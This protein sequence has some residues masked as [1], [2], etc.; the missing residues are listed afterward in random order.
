M[1][2][3]ARFTPAILCVVTVV[4]FACS[5]QTARP[6][7]TTDSRPCA[8]N[9]RTE[10]S[11]WTGRTFKSFQEY[12]NA[13]KANAFDQAGA[14]VAANGWQINTT[15]KDLG[16]IS[17][18]QSVTMGKG[19]TAPLN[20]IVKDRAG[21]GVRVELVF[22]TS[23][24]IAVGEDSLRDGFCKILESV[25][26]PPLVETEKAPAPQAKKKSKGSAKGQEKSK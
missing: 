18:S 5:T 12:P 21:G 26:N 4:S 6:L 3:V 17:A 1:K 10:G 9:L 11:F 14:A 8:A 19:T 7:A 20:A 23:G 2:R 13:T 24:G 25:S 22:Q 16:L 15:N